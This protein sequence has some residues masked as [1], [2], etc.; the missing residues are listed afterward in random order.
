MVII[1][2]ENI[3]NDPK[4]INTKTI[5]KIVQSAKKRKFDYTFTFC[6]ILK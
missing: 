6:P 2:Q 3:K 4:K 5:T 1:I